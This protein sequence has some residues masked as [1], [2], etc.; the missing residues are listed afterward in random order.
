MAGVDDGVRR[1]GLVVGRAVG[2]LV[3]AA[4]APARK[5]TPPDGGASTTSGSSSALAVLTSPKGI[6][7]LACLVAAVVVY[8]FVAGPLSTR[9]LPAATR[10]AGIGSPLASAP[11]LVCGP[12]G[13]HTQAV[14]Q[15]AAT[16]D[17]L[18]LLGRE[19]AG[20]VAGDVSLYQI[21]LDVP[22]EGTAKAALVS[23]TVP[24][25]AD[26]LIQLSA[27]RAPDG[28]SWHLQ[29]ITTCA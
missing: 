16:L 29:G 8:L 24:G 25:S 28:A 21:S 13:T 2:K 3:S 19:G 22:D 20:D 17:D 1:Q 7:S 4:M 14:S 15:T 9:P 18:A 27:T 26:P 6:L 12:E 11:H 23:W 5:K 10:A